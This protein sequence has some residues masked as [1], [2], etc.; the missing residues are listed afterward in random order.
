[1]EILKRVIKKSI[2]I[3]LPLAAISF[4]IE[5]RRLPLGI[6]MGWLFGIFNLRSLTRNV[7]G[8]L[9]PDK[10]TAKIVVLNMARLL[11]LFTAIFFLVYYR[12]VNVIGLLIGFTVVFALILIEGWKVGKGE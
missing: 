1:M 3:I 6:L 10:A 8:L 4:F 2:F 7:E 11:M 5:S 9:R 12:V